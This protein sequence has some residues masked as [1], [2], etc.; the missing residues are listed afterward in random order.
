MSLINRGLSAV[1]RR[2]ESRNRA[3]SLVGDQRFFDPASF[4]WTTSVAAETAAIQREL[5]SV[6]GRVGELPSIQDITPNQVSLTTDA[7]WKTFFLYM[8]GMRI[9]KNCDR[10][11][12]TERA[13]SKIPGLYS[14]F[15]SILAPGKRLPPHRGP[16]NGVLRYHLGLKIPVNDA[17]CAIR[18]GN[19]T[20]SW[21]EGG[22]LIF[23]DTY[24][25]EA[26]NLT[27]EFRAVLFVDFRRPLPWS[28][29]ILNDSMLWLGMKTPLGFAAARN[30][31][32]WEKTF[33]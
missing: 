10:C 4:P 22:S 23:D 6:L 31:A 8:G 17:T 14:A 32:N 20:R 21:S 7:G 28:Q 13:L 15:F 16:Y 9:A 19:E 24:E 27:P 5:G 12:T 18:V 25:H 1:F 11:P 2:M 33:Y 30:Q 26:W 3:T 29:A